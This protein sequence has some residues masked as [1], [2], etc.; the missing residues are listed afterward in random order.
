MKEDF[1][2]SILLNI[3]LD[4]AQ[5]E[6]MEDELLYQVILNP[7]HSITL[8]REVMITAFVNTKTLKTQKT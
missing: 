5:M 1:P 6:S 2:I 7:E 3:V 8:L 4:T